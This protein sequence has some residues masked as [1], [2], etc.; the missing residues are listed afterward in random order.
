M[1]YIRDCNMKRR[2]HRSSY[3]S[4][5]PGAS[6]NNPAL[7]SECIETNPY[8]LGLVPLLVGLVVVGVVVVVGVDVR[9]C[10]V[11]VVDR[12]VVAGVVVAGDVVVVEV[13]V[14]VPLLG[15]VVVGVV[16]AGVVVAGVVVVEVAVVAAGVALI[17]A[18][19]GSGLVC[20][21]AISSGRPVS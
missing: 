2:V 17:T 9:D 10:V 21:L 5:A 19:W 8:G 7:Y 14:E 12:G 11:V 20:T 16:V 6:F 3:I 15:V 13:V 1:P 4:G 18:G